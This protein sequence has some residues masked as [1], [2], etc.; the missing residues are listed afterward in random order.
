MK[1]QANGSVLTWTVLLAGLLVTFS[2]S[3]PLRAQCPNQSF[4]SNTGFCDSICGDGVCDANEDDIS[5]PSDCTPPPPPPSGPRTGM[6]WTVLGQQNGYV[7]VGADAQTNAYAGDATVDQYLPL[8]CLLVDGR[9]APGG[10]SFDFYSGWSRGAV[11]ATAAVRGAALTSQQ[12]G[13]ALCAEA[14]GAGWRLAEFH[15]GRYGADFSATGGWGYWAAGQLTPGTRFWVAIADQP[16]NP[17]NSAGDVP[18]PVVT[19]ED[20]FALKTRLQ[21]LMQPLLAFAQDSRFRDI[22]TNG[23]ARRFDGDDNVLLS[24]VL[25]AAEQAQIVDTSSPSWQALTAKVAQFQ[26][27]NGHTY[28]PQ[29]Y[30][31]NFG[32]GA[33]PDAGV[34]MTV[35]ESDLSRTQLPAY[36]LDGSGGLHLKSE[37][38]DETYAETHEIWVLSVNERIELDPETLATIRALDAKGATSRRS[39]AGKPAVEGTATFTPP[40][41]IS[42]PR[43]SKPTAQALSKGLACNPT[44]LRNNNGREYLQQFRIQN[45]SSVEHWTAG[46]LEP[47]AIIVGKGGAEIGN[48]IFGKIKRNTIKNWYTTD[49][50]LTTWDRATWGDYWAYKW[51]ELDGGPKIEISLGLGDWIKKL[52][53]IPVTLDVKATFDKKFDDMGSGVVAFSESTYTQYGT[54][55]VDWTVCSVGGDG[56]TGNDNL[57][58]SAIAAASSTYPYEG[59]AASRVN[60]GSRDTSLG[61]ASSWV[62]AHSYASNGFLPQWVQLDFGTNKT[63]SRVVVYTSAGYPIQDFNVQIYNGF[64]WV[65]VAS[66]TG[67][68]ALSVTVPFA[69]QTARLVRILGTKGPN[70]Q[71]QYVR[72]NEFEV[73]P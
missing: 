12:Q 28:Y 72:V 5:C 52:L 62:N 41:A 34:T 27:V 43:A 1:R 31:P 45:P 22:V 42:A 6:T 67:N 69:A 14:F 9:P 17:W 59:Y 39:R 24:D 16:A 35:F 48:K 32:D 2:A 44:G 51:V 37:P 38:V 56:G 25:T 53:K 23:V 7:Q 15:D 13:D 29:I 71:P 57:A 11:Q 46:K 18:P 65:T 3:Q 20:D 30:I 33:V 54:G 68:T 21:E 10:I 8:L 64:S 58:I 60:D 70:V 61:G 40:P 49:L 55:I 26:N 73:Y 36:Q 66:V 63:F 50:Y 4:S 47:Q 19:P